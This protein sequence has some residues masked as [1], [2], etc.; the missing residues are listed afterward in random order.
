MNF[1]PCCPGSCSTLER[2]VVLDNLPKDLFPPSEV[3]NIF[4]YPFPLV[5]LLSHFSFCSNVVR[6]YSLHTQAS[7][8]YFDR[9]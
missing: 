7:T 5:V 2:F 6:D 4:L 1:F 8:A 3:C 9:F